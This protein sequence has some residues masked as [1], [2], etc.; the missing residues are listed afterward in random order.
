MGY[1][2]GQLLT[3]ILLPTL[4][5]WI[6]WWISGKK[7]TAASVTFNICLTLILLG[8]IGQAGRRQRVP[9]AMQELQEEKQ[10]LKDQAANS[11]DPAAVDAALDEYSGSIKDKFNKLAE[12]SSG[13]EKQFFTIMRDYVND[14]QEVARKWRETYDAVLAPAIL[15]FSQLTSDEEFARQRSV[16]EAYVA[17]SKAYANVFDNTVS[18]LKQRLSVLGENDEA[19][20]GALEGATEKYIS[21]KPVFGP[22]MQAHIE[23]GQ[24]MIQLL[25]LLQNHKTDWAYVNGELELYT[26][27]MIDEYNKLAESLARHESTI[28]TQARK[29]IENL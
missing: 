18:D 21:Q 2:F 7:K 11:D 23:Y 24:T 13:K 14:S 26:E 28:E 25:D 19:A 10:Q 22:L 15:D 8:Q 6:V 17:E 9:Q 16:I 12:T 3:A 27:T 5:A 20:Q 4:F 29:V 1:F